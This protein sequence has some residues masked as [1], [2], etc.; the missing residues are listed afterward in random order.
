MSVSI[1]IGGGN[2][3]WLQARYVVG[4]LDVTNDSA[5]RGIEKDVEIVASIYRP[6]PNAEPVEFWRKLTDEMDAFW[7]MDAGLEGLPAEALV[8]M[9]QTLETQGGQS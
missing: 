6:G 5:P 8:A 4:R 1:N 7:M 9:D 3:V 2:H